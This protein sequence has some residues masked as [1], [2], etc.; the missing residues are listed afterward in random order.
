MAIAQTVSD[1]FLLNV[2]LPYFS[3]GIFKCALY[4]SSATLNAATSGYTSSG[5][6]SGIGYTAGG[7]DLVPTDGYPLVYNGIAYMQFDNAEWPG[8]SFTA[9]GALIYKAGTGEA[10]VVLDFNRDF[11]VAGQGFRIKFGSSV[12]DALLRATRGQ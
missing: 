8:V 4:T 5:E 7:I 9:R 12:V 6:V 11:T 1:S 10:V 3:S 2:F